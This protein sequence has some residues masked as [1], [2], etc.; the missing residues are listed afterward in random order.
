MGGGEMVGGGIR[1]PEPLLEKK[2][3]SRHLMKP[4]R[5]KN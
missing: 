3:V 5:L 1:P 2:E 4:N